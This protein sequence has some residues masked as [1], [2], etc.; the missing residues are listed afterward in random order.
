MFGFIVALV[1]MITGVLVL[2][3]GAQN[4]KTVEELIIYNGV[5][6]G[7]LIIPMRIWLSQ[8]SKHDQ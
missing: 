5:G 4:W 8:K 2:I 3:H 1:C 7:L 6:L